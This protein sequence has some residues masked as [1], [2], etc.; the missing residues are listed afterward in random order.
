[1]K[2]LNE[3]GQKE[4]LEILNSICAGSFLHVRTILA[5][6]KTYKFTGIDGS[7][8]RKV[9]IE[10][11]IPD[12][13]WEDREDVLGAGILGYEFLDDIDFREFVQEIPAKRRKPKKEVK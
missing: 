13:F 12:R 10:I 9:I 11:A 6:N 2:V 1:M 3:E 8:F 5:P 4:L 7:P